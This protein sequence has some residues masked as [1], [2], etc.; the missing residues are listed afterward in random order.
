MT[1]ELTGKAKVVLYAPGS[2]TELKAKGL[3]R[4]FESSLERLQRVCKG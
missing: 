2:I 4:D 3:S 1:E